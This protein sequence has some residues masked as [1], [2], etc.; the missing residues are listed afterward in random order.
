MMWRNYQRFVDGVRQGMED[1]RAKQALIKTC[2]W[3]V[4]R[5]SPYGTVY[6]GSCC[7]RTHSKTYDGMCPACGKAVIFTEANHG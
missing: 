5:Q 6:L 1:W 2:T 4:V 7:N 3:K